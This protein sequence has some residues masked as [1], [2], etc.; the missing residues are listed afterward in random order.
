M[1]QLKQRRRVVEHV[2]P[3]RQLILGELDLLDGEDTCLD[4]VREE[5][6]RKMAV[7]VGNDRLGQIIIRQSRGF[8]GGCARH[9]VLDVADDV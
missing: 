8:G 2:R 3:L 5:G 6:E 7:E 4:E 1:R 9:F